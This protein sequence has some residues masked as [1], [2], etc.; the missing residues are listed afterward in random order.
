MVSSSAFSKGKPFGY[1]KVISSW[2]AGNSFQAPTTLSILGSSSPIN[3]F[4]GWI[5]SEVK[6]RIIYDIKDLYMEA[7]KWEKP[8][9][10]PAAKQEALML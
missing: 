9:S 2:S 6:I 4:V 5:S 3:P 8:I 10:V 7:A 1:T